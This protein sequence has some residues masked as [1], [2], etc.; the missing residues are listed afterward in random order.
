MHHFQGA[1][2][3]EVSDL[4]TP[5]TQFYC[6]RTWSC[7]P[8]HGTSHGGEAME[9]EGRVVTIS[10]VYPSGCLG[11]LVAKSTHLFVANKGSLLT[12]KARE[13]T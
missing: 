3:V 12:G 7:C 8:A 5:E 9:Q 1:C 6:I 11:A 10:S 13:V 2:T 4:A